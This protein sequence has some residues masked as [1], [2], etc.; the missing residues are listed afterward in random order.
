MKHIY[1]VVIALCL[2]LTFVSCD[3]EEKQPNIVVVLCDDLGYGDLSSF[4]HPI[5]STPNLDRMAENGIKLTNCYSAAPVCSPSRAGLL[6]GRSP[7]KAGI[8][9]F[10]PGLKKSEDC[11]DLVHLQAHEATI[12]Q[13]LKSEGYSTCLSGK[14]H[15]SS[16]FNSDKQPQPDHFGF[17]HWFSTHNNAAPTHENPNNFVRNGE[18]VGQLEGFSCQLVIDEALSWLDSK[19]TDNPFYLQVTFHE[20]HEPIASPKDLVEAYMPKSETEAQAEYFANVTNMDKA[21]GRLITYLED[22]GHDNTLVF[23]TSDNGPETLMRYYRAKKSYGSPGTLK[24]MKLWTAEGGFRVPGIFYWIGKDMYE[25]TSDAVVSSLDLMPTFAELSGAT[26]PNRI[27]DGESVVSLLK[28]GEMQREKPLIWAFYDALNDKYVAMRFG[29]WK[30]IARIKVDGEY[31][32]HIHNLYD[33][34][35]DMVKGAELVDHELYNMKSDMNE[36]SDLATSNS[37]KLQE[38]IL[39]LEKEYKALLDES[40][41]WT[42]SNKK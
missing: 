40:H 18:E 5:I 29:D 13:M 26:L 12:P 33:G 39:L 3:T 36:S 27:L 6:T 22:N 11:R 42:R 16:R 30:I 28:T 9:D 14:W 21:V 23:F 15:C 1:S 41:V 32:G 25:G 24:G 7:N 8:Y 31:M 17:D 34:N 20:P 10:I 19:T 4:G 37:E 2:G 38:M 35:I